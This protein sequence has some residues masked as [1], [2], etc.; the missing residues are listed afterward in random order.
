VV[1]CVVHVV[2]M[3]C[4]VRSSSSGM[5]DMGPGSRQDVARGSWL[6][7]RGRGQWPPRPPPPGW[8][9]E[10]LLGGVQVGGRGSQGRSLEL[11]PPAPTYYVLRTT[12]YYVHPYL[13]KW[14]PR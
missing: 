11:G 6:V 13:G 10:E 1:W 9:L 7:A 12:Y 3:G 5:W 4:A 14:A 8:D 2:A